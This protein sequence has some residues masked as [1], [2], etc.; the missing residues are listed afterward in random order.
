M[1]SMQDKS[2]SYV[3]TD[4]AF[5]C[6]FWCSAFSSL[7]HFA[8]LLTLVWFTHM[9]YTPFFPRNKINCCPSPCFA[10]LNALAGKWI[11]K[12]ITPSVLVWYSSVWNEQLH[13]F[14]GKRSVLLQKAKNFVP[15]ILVLNKYISNT[16]LG[17]KTISALFP[18]KGFT[19]KNSRRWP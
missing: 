11:N 12:T 7:P 17:W 9:N 1:A 6:H 2:K 3:T 18:T 15:D 14:I 19:Q 16:E 5:S 10:F 13:G 4:V 8:P